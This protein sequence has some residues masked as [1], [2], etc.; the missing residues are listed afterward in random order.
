MTTIGVSTPPEPESAS[1]SLAAAD[2]QAVVE[3]L[4]SAPLEE[5]PES[6]PAP[7]TAGPSLRKLALTGSIWAMVAY[8]IS[9]PV[10][11]ATNIVLSWLLV[12]QYF[13]L[14]AMVST[15]LTGLHMFSDIGI[16]PSLVRSH[17]GREPKFVNTA[18]TMGI[19]RGCALTL[20]AFSLAWP[21]AWFYGEREFLWLVPICGLTTFIDGFR[22]TSTSILTRELNLKPVVI[23]DLAAQVIGAVTMIIVALIHPSVW[24]LV[25]GSLTS[26]CASVVMTHLIVIVPPRLCWDRD[27]RR[28]LFHFGKWIFISTVITFFASYCDRLIGGKLFTMEEL[29][30]YYFGLMIA[31]MPRDV[32]YNISEHVVFPLLARKF[33]ESPHDIQEKL[34]EA[35]KII[36]P[37]LMTVALG[38]FFGGRPFFELVYKVDYH[39]AGFVVQYCAPF[40]WFLVLTVMADRLL[41]AM[42]NS[43]ALASA[44][45]VK[46]LTTSGGLILGHWLF[47]M[48]GFVLGL[49][50]GAMCSYLLIAISAHRQGVH[51]LE[52]DLI[53][54]GIL[55]A[56]ALVGVLVFDTER[57]E[58]GMMQIIGPGMLVSLVGLVA[59]RR[60]LPHIRRMRG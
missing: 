14:M 44:N 15:L 8:C 11:L 40:V 6:S 23:I 7:A 45:M 16:G 12:P 4:E 53:H 54:T 34:N 21:A 48:H 39:N 25:A 43:F 57:D 10:R 58:L 27:S 52:G 18:W 3:G 37:L 38:M 26:T 29:G 35:R 28:E 31:M 5:S 47:G 36:M 13:G 2:V 46:L 41:L 24:A 32:V 20:V 22:S 33:R 19:I 60:L 49:A 55:V 17:H 42:G 9:N 30:I 51:I 59:L 56:V 50:F 1:A